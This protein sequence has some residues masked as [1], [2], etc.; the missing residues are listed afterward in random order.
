MEML[1]SVQMVMCSTMNTRQY[2]PSIFC[3]YLVPLLN[4]ATTCYLAIG[5]LVHTKS[6]S[7]SLLSPPSTSYIMSRNLEHFNTNLV[8]ATFSRRKGPTLLKAGR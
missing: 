2:I 3:P 4:F 5:Y 7:A 6:P 8:M 1:Q